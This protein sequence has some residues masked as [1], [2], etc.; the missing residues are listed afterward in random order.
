MLLIK[1]K[2]S[3]HK[4][5]PFSN[6]NIQKCKMRWEWRSVF[7]AREELMQLGSILGKALSWWKQICWC[8][9]CGYSHHKGMR[10]FS[11]NGNVFRN[12]VCEYDNITNPEN[13]CQYSLHTCNI[14]DFF[15]DGE[16]TCFQWADWVF[17]D[18]IMGSRSCSGCQCIIP[19]TVLCNCCFTCWYKCLSGLGYLSDLFFTHFDV[20]LQ[21]CVQRAC[22]YTDINSP[23]VNYLPSITFASTCAMLPSEWWNLTFWYMNAAS[24]MLCA[25]LSAHK[26]I[27]H[28]LVNIDGTVSTQVQNI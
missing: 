14:I 8:M 18:W 13:C 16:C 10:S 19:C 27:S 4:K 26:D 23:I 20:F 5:E 15:S 22:R 3:C 2:M 25:C 21:N 1:L 6:Q 28:F 9:R 7:L 17:L 12:T 24:W 11:C